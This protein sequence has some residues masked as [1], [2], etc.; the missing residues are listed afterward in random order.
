MLKALL[1]RWHAWRAKRAGVALFI[2][3]N[4]LVGLRGE[5]GDVSEIVLTKEEL[6]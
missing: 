5:E 2:H 6:T 3:T 4:V 1:W